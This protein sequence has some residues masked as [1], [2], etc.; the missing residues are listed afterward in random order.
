[1]I[2]SEDSII[3]AIFTFQNSQEARKVIKQLWIHP[4]SETDEFNL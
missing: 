4:I 3:K 2:L 1:M